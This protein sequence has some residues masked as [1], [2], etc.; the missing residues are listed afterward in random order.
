MGDCD[1]GAGVFAEEPLE[2]VDRLG[3]EVVGWFV[4]QEEVGAAEQQATQRD[5]AAF[6]TGEHGD[7]GVVG[8]AAQCVHGDLDVAVEAPCIGGSDLVFENRLLLA[9]LVVVGVGVGP[10]GHHGVVVVNDRLHF[11]DTVHHV[12]ADRLVRIELR[13]LCQIADGVASSEACL[14]LEAVV[15]ASHD[16]EE[17]RLTGAVTA[18][19]ADFDAGVEG[20]RDVLEDRLVRRVDPRELVGLVN[21]FVRHGEAGYR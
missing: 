15:E 7:I 4:E 1:N 3:V 21:K 11:G 18:E 2:P 5:A 20:Q 13:L 9:D 12:A 8:R 17:R 6:T 14:A 10:L 16:L 19:H